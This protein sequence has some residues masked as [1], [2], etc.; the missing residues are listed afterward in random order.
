MS[1]GSILLFLKQDMTVNL[2]TKFQVSSI[3]LTSFR[4]GG[5]VILSLPPLTPKRTSKK[6]TQIRVKIDPLQLFLKSYKDNCTTLILCNKASA[7]K[8]NFK[9]I[10]NTNRTG[11]LSNRNFVEIFFAEQASVVPSSFRTVVLIALRM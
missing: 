10:L 5:G 1:K 4:Q 2:P 8:L 3:T 6:A 11:K 7:L 9:N